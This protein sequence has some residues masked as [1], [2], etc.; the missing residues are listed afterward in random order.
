MT[1]ISIQDG[2]DNMT[3]VTSIHGHNA[4]YVQVK[5]GQTTEVAE[6]ISHLL[7]PTEMTA[8]TTI[9]M[10]SGVDTMT[11]TTSTHLL[12]VVYAKTEEAAKMI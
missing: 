8:M 6:M 4:V 5:H 1:M 2:V 3:L 10:S 12:N 9:G 11:L 7:T